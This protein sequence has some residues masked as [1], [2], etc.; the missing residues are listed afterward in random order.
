MKFEYEQMPEMAPLPIKTKGKSTIGA[1][2]LWIV[3]TRKWKLVSDWKFSMDG[4]QYMIPA[5]F[6]FDGA[7]V[8]KFFR[9][10]LSP[11]GVLLIPGLVHDYGYKY[12]Y[13]LTKYTTESYQIGFQHDQKFFDTVFR[14]A[15]IEVN[16]F[17]Y[18]N[19][20]AYYALRLGGFVAWKGHRKHDKS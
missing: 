3:T 20:M 7:S 18:L 17:K 10:W 9:S 14:D 5:G 16:G 2:W 15:A 6:K 12:S 4:V 11:M 13:L 1:I 19:Y 8:P